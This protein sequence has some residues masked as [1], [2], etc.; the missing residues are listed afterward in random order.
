MAL[1]NPFPKKKSILFRCTHCFDEYELS[2]REV[3]IL[4][5]INHRNP[6]CQAIE[7]CHICHI[8]FMIPVDYTNKQQKRFLFHQIKL[9]IKNLDPNTVM[10]RILEDSVPENIHFFGLFDDDFNKL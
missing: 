7:P 3:R 5:K 2:T 9:K 10:Q 4:E 6:I 1:F 8:G